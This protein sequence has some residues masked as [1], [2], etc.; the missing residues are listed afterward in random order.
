ME[1]QYGRKRHEIQGE[2][3]ILAE[4]NLWESNAFGYFGHMGCVE[5]DKGDPLNVSEF[6][7]G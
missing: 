1:D 7:D 4:R 6:V 3:S 2:V 5:E